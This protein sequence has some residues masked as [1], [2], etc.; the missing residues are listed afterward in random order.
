M[1]LNPFGSG[2]R[3]SRHPLVEGFCSACKPADRRPRWQWC[4]EQVHV[5]VTSPLAGRWRLDASPRVR[6]VM[7]DFADNTVRDTAALLSGAL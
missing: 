4:E 5:D 3:T 2:M 7:E 6:A 1:H